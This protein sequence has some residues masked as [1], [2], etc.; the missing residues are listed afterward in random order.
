MQS[1]RRAAIWAAICVAASNMGGNIGGNWTAGLDV[2]PLAWMLLEGRVGIS[3]LGTSI[4]ASSVP[5]PTQYRSCT[6][7]SQEGETAGLRGRLRWYNRWRLLWKVFFSRGADSWET[8]GRLRE[9]WTSPHMQSCGDRICQS[10]PSARGAGARWERRAESMRRRGALGALA[11]NHDNLYPIA[12]AG[13]IP[14]L[15]ALVRDGSAG[16]KA[17]AT[18]AL[19]NIAAIGYRGGYLSAIGIPML[20]ALVRSGNA[21]GKYN[22]ADALRYFAIGNPIPIAEAGGIPP[23]VA[24]VRYGKAGQN[25]AAAYALANLADDR[26]RGDSRIAIAK[27]G[28]IPPL[29]ALVQYGNDG[30]QEAAAYALEKLAQPIRERHWVNRVNRDNQFLIAEAGGIPPLVRLM[31]YGNEA[32]KERARYAL[33][34][35]AYAHPIIGNKILIPA[36]SARK[37][38]DIWAWLSG[39]GYLGK[40][41][42]RVALEEAWRC[43]NT[44]DCREDAFDYD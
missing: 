35:F 2:G 5:V 20:V 16:Q 21:E 40:N 42:Y 41:E 7:V 1:L 44:E 29:V 17:A 32:Q 4:A 8:R 10:H 37:E 26:R 31:R 39:L 14:P 6:V 36:L 15:L 18:D 38:G 13:G 43:T 22:A 9:S 33:S 28:G 24:L 34:N 11:W 27:A 19:G 23:L 25:E 30:Q 12:E 3:L